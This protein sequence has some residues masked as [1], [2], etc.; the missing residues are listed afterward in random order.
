V[1]R[2]GAILTTLTPGEYFGEMALLSD[3]TR[4]A[5]VRART[6]V[7]VVLIAKG[8]F[9]LL[10]EAVS[11]FAEEFRGKARA[12]AAGATAPPSAGAGPST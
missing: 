1:L 9:A 6:A 12:R 5:T 11:A 2:G 7:D 3:K 10:G 8:D 4:N